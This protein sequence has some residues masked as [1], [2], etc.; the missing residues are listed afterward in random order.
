[1]VTVRSS[2]DRKAAN[3]TTAKN[4]TP[5]ERTVE[6]RT[7]RRGRATSTPPTTGIGGAPM[8][9]GSAAT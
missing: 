2:G 8:T 9:F 7:R 4:V 3:T 5:K 1:M 6:P